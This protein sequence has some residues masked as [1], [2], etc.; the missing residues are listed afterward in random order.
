M[1]YPVNDILFS[2]KKKGNNNTFYNIDEPESI[3]PSERSQSRKITYCTI[4]LT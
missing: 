3:I 1:V 4:P 2:N